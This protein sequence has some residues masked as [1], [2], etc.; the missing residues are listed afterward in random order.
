MGNAIIIATVDTY[1]VPKII[2]S[3]DKVSGDC[4]GFH[5][6]PVMNLKIGTSLKNTRLSLN[7][8]I[9]IKDN[10]S[11]ENRVNILIPA[12]NNL[13]NDFHIYIT[14]RNLKKIQGL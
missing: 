6:L 10:S 14:S 11:I 1:N 8:K 7:M 3:M 2:F 5:V 4:S 13:S 9:I 12:S